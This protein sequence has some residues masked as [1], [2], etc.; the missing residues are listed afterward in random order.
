MLAFFALVQNGSNL[1]FIPLF[2]QI[3]HTIQ[4]RGNQ[5]AWATAIR[6]KAADYIFHVFFE[7]KQICPREHSRFELQIIRPQ[8]FALRD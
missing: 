1:F 5:Q 4:L 8:A 7:I 2:L 3:N 6:R